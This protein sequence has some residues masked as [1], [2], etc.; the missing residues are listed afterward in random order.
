MVINQYGAPNLPII[1]LLAPMMISG[2]DIYKIMKPCFEGEYCFIAP[3][4]GGHGVAR[5]YESADREYAVLKHFLKAGGH[6]E[7]SMVYGAFLG[8][9]VAYRM[10]TD[11]DFQ[12]DKIWLDGVALNRSASFLERMMRQLFRKKKKALTRKPEEVSPSLVKMYGYEV[13]RLMTKNFERMT[14]ED[15][16]HIC[17]ACCHYNLKTFSREEQSKIHLDYG[18]K[19]PTYKVSVQGLKRYMPEVVPVIRKGYNHCQYM[20]VHTKEYVEEIERFLNKE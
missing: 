14:L 17:H 11:P 20:A 19:D 18:E 2:S 3:D 1:I 4:Q 16:D 15:I 10:F 5:S 7:I 13:G 8:G 6:S 9:A 12:V